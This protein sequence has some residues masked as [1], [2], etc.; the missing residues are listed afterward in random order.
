MRPGPSAPVSSSDIQELHVLCI[1]L[2]EDAAR[3]DGIAHQH[4]EGAVRSVRILDVDPDQQPLRG[5]HGRVPELVGVHL[6]EALEARELHADLRRVENVLAQLAERLRDD[7]L[8]AN[9]HRVRRQPD[10]VGQLRVALPHIAVDRRAEQLDR[11]AD[12]E[13]RARLRLD[14]ADLERIVVIA[15]QRELVAVG[16]DRLDRLGDVAGLLDLVLDEAVVD[17]QI[18]GGRAEVR[19]QARRDAVVLR[20]LLREPPPLRLRQLH[21]IAVAI[22]DLDRRNALAGEELLELRL[23]L[24]VEL[25]TPEL[26]TVERRRCD[27]DMAALDQRRHLP[28]EEREDERADVRAVD[29]GVRHHDD[30]VVAQ[31]RDVELVADAGAD[32]GDHRLDLVVREHLVDAVL[33][34]VDDLPAQ[35]QDRLVGAVAAL[36]GGAAGGIALDD[37]ELCDLWIVDRAVRKLARQRH[38]LERR[39]AP[40]QLAR[41]TPREPRARSRDRLADDLARVGRIL[42]EELGQ[43]RVDRRLDETGDRRV[44]ELRLRLPLELRVLQLDGDHPGEALANVLPFEVVLLLLQQALVARVLVERARQRRAEAL[45][46]GAALDRV[47]VVGEREDG[48][49][50][51]GVPLHGDLDVARV[52]LALE[53]RDVPVHRVLRLVDVA[54]EVLDTALVVK[55]DAIATR[56][57]VGEDD[58]QAARQERRLA[59][60]LPQRLGGELELVEYLGVGQEGDRHPGLVRDPARLHVALRH[61]AGELLAVDLAVTLDIGDQPFR[62]RVHDR[63]ADAVQAAGDLVAAAAELAAGVQ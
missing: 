18:G 56:A 4:R 60:A 43:P 50:V 21:G 63:R 49:L 26:R 53:V 11:N 16:R 47:D 38:A 22:G 14:E 55:L 36:L 44:A 62:E 20:K 48:L 29:V 41:L 19:A 1:G 31:L 28:V 32:R 57:L 17:H 3:L 25:L 42:L 9:G 30:A 34:G 23:L 27:V 51:R 59:E 12:R 35:R 6:D 33:L 2:D 54:D 10:D 37:E 52:A 13:R 15:E 8:L 7:P 45:H 39:L 58:A 46:V 5:I 24:E 40:R 61:T